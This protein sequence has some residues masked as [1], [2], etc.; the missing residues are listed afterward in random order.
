MLGLV[1][2]LPLALAAEEPPIQV[3]PNRPT[4]AT[5]ALTTQLGVAELEIGLQRSAARDEERL[6]F[7]PFLM[8]FGLLKDVELRVGGNG[9]LRQTQAATSAATG[10]GDTTLGAQ[11]CY[12]R[13]GPLGVDEAVQLT[14]K[15]PTASAAKGLGSGEPDE[16]LMLLLSRDL[17]PFHADANLLSTRRGRPAAEGGGTAFQPAATLSISRTVDE[18]WSLTGELYWIGAT[19]HNARIVSNLWALGFKVSPRLVLDAGV[20]VGLSHG[21]QKLSLFTGLT[22]GMFRVRRPPAQ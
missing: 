17:G 15:V 5:P 7:T 13:N 1:L 14:L 3:N 18:Q 2:S 22:V 19:P 12:L 9:L 10:G 16:T 21:A 4:F 20:D 8:K 6:S 11:W